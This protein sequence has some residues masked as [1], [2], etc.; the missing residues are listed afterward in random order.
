MKGILAV[1]GFCIFMS[2]CTSIG[3]FIAAPNLST[4]TPAAGKARVYVIRVAKYAWKLALPIYKNGEHIATTRGLCYVAWDEEP[5]QIKLMAQAK[6]DYELS[7]DVEA[8]KT[9]Y[10]QQRVYASGL[11]SANELIVRD[12]KLGKE[13]LAKGKPLPIVAK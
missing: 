5:G 2:G 8:G 12:E 10:I 7:L 1:F 11:A 6:N 3:Q 9:Y 4:D 13:L